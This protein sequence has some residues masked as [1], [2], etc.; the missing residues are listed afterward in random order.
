VFRSGCWLQVHKWSQGVLEH[1]PHPQR[2]SLWEKHVTG[3]TVD[4][5][6]LWDQAQAVLVRAQ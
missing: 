5:C 1:L 3:K 4:T 6:E 2:S